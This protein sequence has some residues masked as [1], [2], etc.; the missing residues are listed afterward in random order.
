MN[1]SLMPV[2]RRLLLTPIPAHLTPEPHNIDIMNVGFVAVE[3][4]FHFGAVGAEGAGV[5]EDVYVVDE[6]VLF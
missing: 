1:V 2:Q 6:V 4:A 3:V 5:P